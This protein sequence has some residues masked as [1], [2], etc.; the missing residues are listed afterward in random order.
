[1]GILGPLAQGG[2][3]ASARARVSHLLGA[4]KLDQRC[5][6]PRAGFPRAPLP[7]QRF[8]A[9]LATGIRFCL[10]ALTSAS[11]SRSVCPA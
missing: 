2:P 3:S 8:H 6:P 5:I 9:V 7:W 11:W 10:A 4:G 1:M